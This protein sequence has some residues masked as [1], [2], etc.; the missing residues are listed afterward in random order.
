VQIFQYGLELSYTKQAATGQL[1]GEAILGNQPV[2]DEAAFQLRLKLERAARDVEYSFL[3]GVYQKPVDNLTGRKTRGLTSAITTNAVAAGLTDLSTDHLKDL[4]RTMADNGAPFRNI[5]L[6][7]N[8]F[9]RQRVTDVFA[10][11]PEDR[12]VGGVSIKQVETDFTNFG[13]A[14]DRH[15][16]N[17][18]V[19]LVDV[20]L[21]K[22]VMLAIPGKGH[23][24]IEPK[25]ATGASDKW[26]LY[27]EIGLEYGPEAWHGKV[28]GTTTS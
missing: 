28:T 4:V 2:S 14:Y 24:F 22:P 7:A 27:G 12:H 3:R 23:F 11:A 13:V 16:L 15:M 5:V 18:E 17:S 20:S 19:F 9:N 8:S 1:G 21:V 6:F 10:Y 26:Q 25:P